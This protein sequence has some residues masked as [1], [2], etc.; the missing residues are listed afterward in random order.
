MIW[1]LSQ[2][3]KTSPFHGEG[4]SSTLPG[5]TSGCMANRTP[6]TNNEKLVG[7]ENNYKADP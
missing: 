7:C 6:F 2:A 1:P 4:G 5:V 3:A